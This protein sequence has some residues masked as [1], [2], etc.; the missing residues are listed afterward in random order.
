MKGTE[1]AP[2]VFSQER[3]LQ[4]GLGRG[5]KLPCP[6][7]QPDP[8]RAVPGFR[9]AYTRDPYAIF[10]EFT[11]VTSVGDVRSDAE[12]PPAASTNPLREHQPV[13][14]RD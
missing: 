4:Q 12:C 7:L 14:F 13:H 9:G 10:S 3:R 2:T 5:K 8:R 11:M 1:T 6:R